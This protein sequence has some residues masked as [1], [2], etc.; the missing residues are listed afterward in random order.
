[1]SIPSDGTATINEVDGTITYTPNVDFVGT[2]TFAYLVSDIQ[3]GTDTAVVEI[4]VVEASSSTTPNVSPVAV[5]DTAK[6]VQGT[7]VEVS[8]LDNDSD[9]NIED[10]LSVTLVGETQHGT[11][12]TDSD[13]QT[14]LYTPDAVFVGTERFS[15]T[16]SDGNGNTATAFVSVDVTP[17][18]GLPEA[19]DDTVT[20]L[21]NTPVIV[22]VLKNDS[23]PD[24]GDKLLIA[25]IDDTSSEGAVLINNAKR[26]VTYLPATDFVGTDTFQYTVEDQKGEAASATV[27]VEVKEAE[28]SAVRAVPE[29][30]QKD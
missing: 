24:N 1:V 26:A 13:K 5:D 12:T 18:N 7:T 2:D 20:T 28:A 11:T 4:K 16:I 3:G 9:A 29:D 8:V 15:Y 14:I 6:A 27:T 19:Q 21:K 22:H 17:T 25:S 30:D 23:D 10:V